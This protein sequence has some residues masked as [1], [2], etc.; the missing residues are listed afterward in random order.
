MVKRIKHNPSI[1]TEQETE[2]FPPK[3][4]RAPQICEAKRQTARLQGGPSISHWNPHVLLLT[5]VYREPLQ[6][7]GEGK[8]SLKT[9]ALFERLSP[10]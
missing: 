1:T 4:V 9:L 10:N 6:A 8:Q 2:L 5:G 3:T 7:L